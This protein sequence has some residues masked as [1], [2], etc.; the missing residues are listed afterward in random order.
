MELQIKYSPGNEGY[1]KSKNNFENTLSA[2]FTNIS[3]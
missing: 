2:N 3:L 1:L